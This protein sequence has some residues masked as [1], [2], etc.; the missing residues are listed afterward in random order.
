[1][2]IKGRNCDTAWFAMVDHQWTDLNEAFDVSLS[3]C[4]FDVK[5]AQKENL[6]N[7]ATK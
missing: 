3:R 1:M 5:G 2:I 6:G 7:R 4:N